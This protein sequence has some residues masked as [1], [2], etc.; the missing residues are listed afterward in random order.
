MELQRI[1]RRMLVGAGTATLALGIIVAAGGY[2]TA[3]PVTGEIR[4]AGSAK[5]VAGSYIVV[6][7]DGTV[8]TVNTR[9]G[10]LAGKYGGAVRDVYSAAIPG[11]EAK[12]S[13]AAAKR[14]AA[15]PAVAYV[16]QN[17]TVQIQATQNNATWGI[18]RI[19]QANL[20]LSTTYTYNFTGSGV[21]A[22]IIDTGIL[23]THSDFGGRAAHGYDFVNNDS[24]ATDCNGHGTHVAGTV[25]GNTYG[26]A[27]AVR[28]V[29]VRVLGC[30]GGGTTAGVISGVNWVTQNAQKPAVANM[31]LGGGASTTLDTAVR[32]SI[33]AGISYAVAAGNS[34]TNACN[35]SPAR[36]PTAITV[37]ATTRTD[38][39][40]SFS[41]Y[42]SC[43]DIFAP[44][45]SI[46]SAWYTTTTATST[47]SGT[48]MAS[49]HVAGAAALVLQANPSFTPAQVAS[50]LTTN[51]VANK[52]TSPGTSSPNRLLQTPR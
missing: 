47:I 21:T 48:S 22:Y 1:S 50:W 6:L 33:A 42:G 49:P 8:S 34:N 35:S 17:Q 7:K 24:N 3:A 2:A 27:K 10:K 51:A 11:F 45:T 28:L 25:G 9:A 40:S 31:S 13:E 43:L 46:T 18:D 39:R 23:T 36:V 26:V 4:M 12:M 29:G 15:D 32:N 14:L 37:G 5:A 52:V 16:E 20:P 30:T 44:G 38:A 41:N 19:D